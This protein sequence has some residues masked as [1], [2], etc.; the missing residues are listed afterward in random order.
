MQK[1]VNSEFPQAAALLQPHSN[2]PRLIKIENITLNVQPQRLVKDNERINGFSACSKSYSSCNGLKTSS[3]ISPKQTFRSS[4]IANIALSTSASFPITRPFVGQSGTSASDA[5]QQNASALSTTTW[6]NAV[7]QGGPGRPTFKITRYI[8]PTSTLVNQL[9]NSRATRRRIETHALG[10]DDVNS[11]SAFTETTNVAFLTQ[12]RKKIGFPSSHLHRQVSDPVSGDHRSHTSPKDL[13]AFESPLSWPYRIPQRQCSSF[14][15]MNRR[16]DGNFCTRGAVRPIHHYPRATYRISGISNPSSCPLPDSVNS[17]FLGRHY[18]TFHVQSTVDSKRADIFNGQSAKIPDHTLPVPPGAR[19]GKLFAGMMSESVQDSALA[20]SCSS[21]GIDLRSH[22]TSLASRSSSLVNDEA[23][24]DSHDTRD[25]ENPLRK[26]LQGDSASSDDKSP[27]IFLERST[28]SSTSSKLRQHKQQTRVLMD[29]RKDLLRDIA[30][31]YSNLLRLMNEE[32]ILTGVDPEGYSD[33]VRAYEEAMDQFEIIGMNNV[34]HSSPIKT[35]DTG[36]PSTIK[37]TTYPLPMS[38]L[39]R[40]TVGSLQN[41]HMLPEDAKKGTVDSSANCRHSSLKNRAG[42]VPRERLPPHDSSHAGTQDSPGSVN[43]PQRADQRPSLRKWLSLRGLSGSATLP[44][45]RTQTSLP[46]MSAFRR[47][48]SDNNS[49]TEHHHLNPSELDDLIAWKEIEAKTVE[50]ILAENR[51]LSTDRSRSRK[52]RLAYNATAEENVAKLRTLMKELAELKKQKG[53]TVA[54]TTKADVTA[55]CTNVPATKSSLSSENASIGSGCEGADAF[56]PL[57]SISTDSADMRRPYVG[58][59]TMNSSRVSP[60]SFEV[61][62]G[63]T[64]SVVQ[65]KSPRIDDHLHQLVDRGKSTPYVHN[66]EKRRNILTL[67]H[68]PS[69]KMQSSIISSRPN[70]EV[71]RSLDEEQ[72]NY[73]SRLQPPGCSKH[74]A[75]SIPKQPHVS[76]SSAEQKSNPMQINPTQLSQNDSLDGTSP[77]GRFPRTPHMEEDV[78]HSRTPCS[79]H[80]KLRSATS[81]QDIFPAQRSQNNYAR[82]F[83]VYSNPSFQRPFSNYTCSSNRPNYQPRART[84]VR[85]LSMSPEPQTS[86]D[87]S[88]ALRLTYTGSSDCNVPVS[89]MHTCTVDRGLLGYTLGQ[90]NA[91]GSF[92]SPG[93]V[94]T[95]FM[96]KSVKIDD[97]RSRYNEE[98][99]GTRSAVP[100]ASGHRKPFTLADKLNMSASTLN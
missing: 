73:L 8:A 94:H 52:A 28:E 24:A 97:N 58:I 22:T 92:Q 41:L 1:T 68:S 57:S 45:T 95:N 27:S 99:I 75:P 48:D 50:N 39:S 23:S 64:T 13:L 66:D 25:R 16:H 12:S 53:S 86:P 35:K 19:N 4:I 72:M 38:T 29:R 21:S 20:I 56:L 63:S 2:G 67:E 40:I 15:Q 83:P 7:I 76:N 79:C 71:Q 47:L 6:T 80:R 18:T 74:L 98:R 91:E 89:N 43:S 87:N 70:W 85:P 5:P 3:H 81:Y 10:N 36:S 88:K 14:Q 32:R 93:L 65:I 49:Q 60:K 100:L 42:S 59:D 44:N 17:S 90:E 34:R 31:E 61:Q 69:S 62:F 51:C 77:L 11:N 82:N 37:R 30:Q 96:P 84:H 54:V 26:T 33:F 55:K 9:S 46:R 78:F